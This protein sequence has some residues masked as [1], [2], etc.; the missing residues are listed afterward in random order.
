MVKLNTSREIKMENKKT[1]YFIV[2]TVL[3]VSLFVAGWY[4]KKGTDRKNED[5]DVRQEGSVPAAEDKSVEE[6]IKEIE[7]ILKQ[8]SSEEKAPADA[9]P[10]EEQIKEVE[11]ILK[12]NQPTTPVVQDGK[13]VE[14]QIKE[15]EA[16]LKENK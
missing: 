16:M 10:M 12:Q 11:E 4:L 15:V 14:E 6:Q 7:E 8:Q 1:L 2:G 9:R 5:M 13:S 3:L